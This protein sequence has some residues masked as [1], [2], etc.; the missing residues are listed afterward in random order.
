MSDV[1]SAFAFGNYNN[2]SKNIDKIKSEYNRNIIEE[3]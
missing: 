1:Y 3:F 2:T